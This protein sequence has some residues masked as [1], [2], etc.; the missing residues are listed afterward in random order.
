MVHGKNQHF[1]SQFYFR[2]F[3]LDGKTICLFNLNNKKFIQSASIKDQCSKDYFYSKD[4][5][6]ETL[7]SSL[8]TSS[9]ELISQIIN[10]QNLSCLSEE[11]KQTLKRYLLFQHGR[12]EYARDS[13]EETANALFELYKPNIAECAKDQGVE[14]STE[15]LKNMKIKSNSKN[16]V[17]LSLVSGPL[18]Y[19]LSMILLDNKTQTDFIFSDN[20]VVF[21]NS[22][23][24]DKVPN[25]TEGIS[26]TGLQIYF[27]LNSKLAL[28]IFDPTFY[29]LGQSEKTTIN[30]DSD[31]QR[32]NGLQIL[33]CNEHI[34]FGNMR[35]KDQ[36]FLRYNQ[37]KSKRPKQK[38]VN[39]VV[40]SRIAEDGTYRELWHT[41]STKIKY[42]L[43][44]L[45]FLKHKK[46]EIPYGL[47]NPEMTEINYNILDAI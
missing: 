17:L 35:M 43:E 3:S 12:T 32:L 16:S 34:Y 27:P 46:T 30:K 38:T 24:N 21:Y 40:A 41:S 23:F 25:G 39:G 47:R 11:Q 36:I 13:E 22:F 5:R 1:V 29:D 44:D 18:L 26:S 14:I 20:P 2:N 42:N 6:V 19:D 7:F 31:I 33:Y 10:N 45:S 8:E 15:K 28:F 4:P 9:K 37:L